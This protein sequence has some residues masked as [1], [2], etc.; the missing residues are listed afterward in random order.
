MKVTQLLLG[1][2][3]LIV[4]LL[5]CLGAL[6]LYTSCISFLILINA[7][8]G[9][10]LIKKNIP[11]LLLQVIQL[12]SLS[13]LVMSIFTIQPNTTLLYLTLLSSSITFFYKHNHTHS[14]RCHLTLI[15]TLYFI[16]FNPFNF[17]QL[18]ILFIS[19]P[20]LLKL[21]YY[22][23]FFKT[24]SQ[25]ILWA[26]KLSFSSFSLALLLYLTAPRLAEPEIDYSYTDVGSTKRSATHSLFT[27]QEDDLISLK[28]VNKLKLMQEPI[29]DYSYKFLTPPRQQHPYLYLKKQSYEIYQDGLWK[30]NITEATLLLDSEDGQQ[31]DWVQIQPE[32]SPTLEVKIIPLLPISSYFGY[33]QVIAYQTDQL[34]IKGDDNYGKIDQNQSL[35]Y[36]FLSHLNNSANLSLPTSGSILPN[37][38]CT[39]IPEHLKPILQEIN[40]EFP[41]N[42]S[43]FE[44]LKFIQNYFKSNYN[45]SLSIERE[46]EEPLLDLLNQKQGWCEHFATAMTLLARS[47]GYPARVASGLCLL[48]PDSFPN[49]DTARLSHSHTWTEVYIEG[50]GWTLWDAT[51]EDGLPNTNSTRLEDQALASNPFIDFFQLLQQNVK[52]SQSFTPLHK[53]ILLILILSSLII[54]L[55]SVLKKKTSEIDS[56]RLTNEPKAYQPPQLSGIW[57]QVDS[58]LLDLHKLKSNELLTQHIKR[59][60]SDY[61]TISFTELLKLH[62]SVTWG[63]QTLT[64]EKQ[65]WIESELMQIQEIIESVSAS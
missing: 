52:S 47:Y 10:K 30:T 20:I 51:P 32:L 36:T 19:A 13:F 62:N 27:D 41:P 49:I 22:C 43:H 28:D 53:T 54:T 26:L 40:S 29:F 9:S 23:S 6:D 60:Q 16:H 25:S 12:S 33:G 57:K 1:N 8:I 56:E 45:Y 4:Y 3:L 7:F 24:S 44:Q 21:I 15:L 42:L 61:P 14:I 35:E 64:S 34:F 46:G 55:I 59:I 58:A 5:A 65:Q 63:K 2:Q 37:Q 11:E 31:D 17:L 39:E 38:H 48:T 18:L 50:L